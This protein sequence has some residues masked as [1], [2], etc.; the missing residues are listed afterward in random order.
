MGCLARFV[1]SE[2]PKTGVTEIEEEVKEKEEVSPL[3]RRHESAKPI[4]AK[5][6][7]VLIE[8]RFRLGE[9]DSENER[10]QDI[11]GMFGLGISAFQDRPDF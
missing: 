7:E 8:A 3:M 4:V 9:L 1:P 10:S 6:M 2:R 5:M 11:P